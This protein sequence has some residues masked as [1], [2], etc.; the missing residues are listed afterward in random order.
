MRL[1]LNNL[2]K[3]LI[4]YSE[5]YVEPEYEPTSIQSQAFSPLYFPHPISVTFLT[6]TNLIDLY[7]W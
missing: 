4:Y 3:V 6:S 7:P 2:P 5:K 1:I